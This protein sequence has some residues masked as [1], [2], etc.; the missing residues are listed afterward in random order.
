MA[1]PTKLQ[2]TLDAITLIFLNESLKQPVVV[3]FEDLFWIDPQ[4][5][6]LLDLLADSL[7]KPGSYYWSTTDPSIGTSGSTGC[8]ATWGSLAGGLKRS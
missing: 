2:R 8:V 1:P 5:Q 6:A 4:T 3:I 7:G